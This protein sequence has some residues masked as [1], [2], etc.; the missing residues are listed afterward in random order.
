MQE[1]N[2]AGGGSHMTKEQSV[3][4]R[5]KRS[6][7]FRVTEGEG[8]GQRRIR[9]GGQGLNTA[10]SVHGSHPYF[11]LPRQTV[12]SASQNYLTGL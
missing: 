8:R 9:G 4:K 5:R 2:L 1:K 10:D 12:L 6:T 3:P 7:V 11:L